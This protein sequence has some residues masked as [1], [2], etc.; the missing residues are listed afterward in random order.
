[1]LFSH[2]TFFCTARGSSSIM[3]SLNSEGRSSFV[4]GVFRSLLQYHLGSS[5]HFEFFE[6]TRH[7]MFHSNGLSTLRNC[8]HT[9]TVWQ[10]G[11]VQAHVLE[12][13]VRQAFWFCNNQRSCCSAWCA[14]L[15]FL[16][17]P[18]FLEYEVPVMFSLPVDRC[19]TSMKLNIHHKPTSAFSCASNSLE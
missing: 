9:W 13:Q 18:C 7:Q 5:C 16:T 15:R 12:P 6:K 19:Q 4:Q 8:F 10:V 3:L 11:I 17:V 2:S 1:M 14:Y